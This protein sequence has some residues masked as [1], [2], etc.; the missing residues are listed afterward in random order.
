MIAVKIVVL[1]LVFVL[2]ASLYFVLYKNGQKSTIDDQLKESG[3][4]L[5]EKWF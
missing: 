2:F 5:Q 4:Y 3:S 1:T